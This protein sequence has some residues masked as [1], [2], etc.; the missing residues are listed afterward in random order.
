MRK[1]SKSRNKIKAI[2]HELKVKPPRV[3]AKTARK[4]GAKAA[5]RQRVAIL[6]SKARA[7]GIAV[8]GKRGR[9]RGSKRR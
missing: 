2:G 4:K 8:P 9:R 6:L 5:D 7:A 3:L 1:Q